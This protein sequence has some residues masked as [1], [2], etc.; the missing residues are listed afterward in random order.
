VSAP[1]RTVLPAIFRHAQSLYDGLDAASVVEIVNDVPLKVFRG[2]LTKEYS[3]IGASQSYYTPVTKALAENGCV[4]YLQ[5]GVR[6]VETVAALHHPPRE[7]LWQDSGRG[8]TSSTGYTILAQLVQ[9]IE[10]SL[11]GVNVPQ[12][13][14]D[15]QQQ[16]ERLESRVRTLE[17]GS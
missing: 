11:G 15:L 5:K 12:A 7:D 3:K 16:L 2:S 14:Y 4:T 1:E 17:G 6:G 13:L 9:N 10:E 8:L